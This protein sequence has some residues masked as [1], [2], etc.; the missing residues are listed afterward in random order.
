MA[1]KDTL[2]TSDWETLQLGVIAMFWGV[3]GADGK[4]DEK[5]ISVFATE[6]MEAPL[7][8]SDLAKEVFGTI[9]GQLAVLLEKY[10]ADPRDLLKHLTDVADV[11]D[12]VV[13]G[14][15]R[16]G[17]KRALLAVAVKVAQASGGMFGF[18]DKIS[19][20]EKAAVTALGVALRFVG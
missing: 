11:L 18:G 8:K 17:F 15:E 1:F 20:N 3:A 5:E 6:M 19:K 12:R 9:F 14:P 7:Y 2:S 13:G 4:V 10:K 16:E